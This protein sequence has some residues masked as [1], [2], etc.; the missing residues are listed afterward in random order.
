MCG[1][2]DADR[3]SNKDIVRGR[4]DMRDILRRDKDFLRKQVCKRDDRPG[5]RAD[6]RVHDTVH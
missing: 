4:R 6:G 3:K 1:S 5:E 2:G